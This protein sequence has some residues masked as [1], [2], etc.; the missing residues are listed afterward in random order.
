VPPNISL[1]ASYSL[2]KPIECYDDDR[3]SKREL[4]CYLATVAMLV[5]SC[6]ERACVFAIADFIMS[7]ARA[8][9]QTHIDLLLRLAP[10][11]GWEPMA[12]MTTKAATKRAKRRMG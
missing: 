3:A 1:L 8:G 2:R 5:N 7:P 10:C 11:R 12:T 4:R 6:V 9:M